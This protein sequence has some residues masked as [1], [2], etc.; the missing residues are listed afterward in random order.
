MG[1][2][3]GLVVGLVG[4][5]LVAVAVVLGKG[6]GESSAATGEG[7]QLTLAFQYSGSKELTNRKVSSKNH[8]YGPI[9][10]SLDGRELGVEH[11]GRGF[12]L[13]ATTSLGMHDLIFCWEE[14]KE[15]DHEKMYAAHEA[16]NR[17][18]GGKFGGYEPSPPTTSDHRQELE[19]NC[20][21]AGRCVVRL[22]FSSGAFFVKSIDPKR[23]AVV[24][25]K[26]GTI[27]TLVLIGIGCVVVGIG[28]GILW[29]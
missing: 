20:L 4:A 23:A 11:G 19:L 21:K 25:A 2:L 5:G 22:G 13:E 9:Q 1:I 17:A 7:D 14:M 18:S 16:L 12:Q 27:L 26:K 10:V 28:I 24:P 29:H 15:Y 3:V 6:R 8:S